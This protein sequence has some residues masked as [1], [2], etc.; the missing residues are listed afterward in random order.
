MTAP[1]TKRAQTAAR[2]AALRERRAA[3]GLVRL[4]L[5]VRPG[6]VAA[7]RHYAERLVD[8]KPAEREPGG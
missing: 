7:I 4:E 2:V 1:P 8:K 3:L 6:D 5:W